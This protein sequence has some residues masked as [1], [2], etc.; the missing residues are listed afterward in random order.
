M[1]DAAPAAVHLSDYAPPAWL[2]E[3][4]ELTFR[5][6]PTATRVLS[7]IVFRPNPETTDRTFRLDGE[8]LMLVSAKID[9][10][11]VTPDITPEGLTCPAPDAP[12]LWEAEV[13]IAPEANT[14]LEG[15]YMSRGMYC[16]Q[17][18]AEGFRKI[19]FYP[20]RPD[21]MAPFHVRIEGDAAGD[22]V[23][24]QPRRRRPRLGRMDR[25]LAQARLPLRARRRRLSS[26][27]PTPSRRLR[28][29]RSRSTSGCARA[30][31]TAA[32]T[33]WT[34]SSGR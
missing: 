19:T 24:R 11:P 12:F 26:P 4:V 8:S 32:T 23:E 22:A 3:R 30:T 31:R 14:A 21:V 15:L 20:D 29:A 2:V 18:E 34:R 1:K 27:I 13:E 7:R 33:R 6:H 17:C 10:Q 28:A 5:L 16:T 25:P 9:G